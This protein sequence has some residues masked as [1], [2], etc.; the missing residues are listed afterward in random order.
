MGMPCAWVV[1]GD[2]GKFLVYFLPG[3]GEPSL[4]ASVRVGSSMMD[5]LFDSHGTV[6]ARRQ[7]VEA[8]QSPR[9]PDGRD[10]CTSP[11]WVK[12]GVDMVLVVCVALAIQKLDAKVAPHSCRSSWTSNLL[13]P[14]PL[15]S[16]V[17]I[18]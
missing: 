2:A 10:L 6:L 4:T 17:S 14:R 15:H 7:H 18:R 5:A 9:R 12:Q 3:D 11:L 1:P 8:A 13:A 16:T